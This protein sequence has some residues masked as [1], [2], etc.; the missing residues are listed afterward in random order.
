[1]MG[2][3]Q[4]AQETDLLIDYSSTSR[5]RITASIVKYMYS[6]PGNQ[7]PGYIID[8]LKKEFKNFSNWYLTAA[9]IKQAQQQKNA[10]PVINYLAGVPD[11]PIE[12]M[13]RN[14]IVGLMMLQYHAGQE[15]HSQQTATTLLNKFNQ[16][17]HQTPASYRF[18]DLARM[19]VLAAFYS[20]E[21][22]QAAKILN[23]GFPANHTCWL[24]D[25]AQ[26][27]I[28]LSP[29]SEHPSVV[30]YLNRIERDI[31]RARAKLNLN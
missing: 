1:M 9:L 31:K 28:A 2:A 16:Y 26:M 30:E 12:I 13:N 6:Q 17:L 11:F 7:L 29:W 15:E 8:F 24:D 22:E 10:E 27:R 5:G 19:H 25:I 3:V 21:I 4:T 20:G 23:S 14:E 18:Y